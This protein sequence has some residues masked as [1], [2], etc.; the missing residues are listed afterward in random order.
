[1]KD[2]NVSIITNKQQ[3]TINLEI[4]LIEESKNGG[5]P[6]VKFNLSHTNPQTEFENEPSSSNPAS[7]AEP[8]NPESEDEPSSSNPA[9]PADPNDSEDSEN[10]TL[11][12]N[13]RKTNPLKHS[14]PVYKLRPQCKLK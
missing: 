14:S 8:N 13:F 2:V 12:D 3:D 1:L 6:G 5:G 11:A 10:E 9:S 4:P 7:P